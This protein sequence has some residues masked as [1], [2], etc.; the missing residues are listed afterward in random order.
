MQQANFKTH[1]QRMIKLNHPPKFDYI[2]E[3][4]IENITKFKYKSSCVE[5]VTDEALANS[6]ATTSRSATHIAATIKK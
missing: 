6:T 2:D 4:T 1:Y 3:K 5:K